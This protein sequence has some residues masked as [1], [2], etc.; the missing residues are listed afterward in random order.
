M[1]KILVLAFIASNLV[2][3]AQMFKSPEVSYGYW[4]AQEN[5]PEWVKTM[6]SEKSDPQKTISQFEKYYQTHEFV[7]NQHT[8]YYKRWL[9]SFARDK[10][11]IELSI[12][13]KKELERSTTNYLENSKA[14]L[15]SRTPTSPWKGIGPIDFDKESVSRSYAAG[16][17]HIYTVEQ[18]STNDSLLYAGTATAGL[19][20]SVDKGNNWISITD[21]MLINSIVAVEIDHVNDE[22]VYFGASNSLYKTIDGGANW[23]I[24]GDANFRAKEHYIPEIRLSP[25]DNNLLFV[26]SDFGL[27]RSTD[28]GSNFSEI[29]S[30][31]FQELEFHPSDPSIIY[32]VR[33]I[34]D[35][36]EFYKSTDNGLTF[37]LKSSGW[38]SPTSPDE[39]KRT[40][41]ATT[42]HAPNKVY[43]L[44][45]GAANGGS[46]LYGMYVSSDQ[47]ETWQRSCCGSEEAGVP[48][49]SNQ[50]LMG[51]ADDGTDDGGQYYYDLALEVDDNDSNKVF[52]AGVNLW[53][54]SDGGSTFTCPAKWSHSYK[55]NYVHADIH[56][57]KYSGDEIW[58][59]CDGGI[60]YSKNDGATFDRKMKGIE[61]T[62]FWGF[63]VGHWDGEVILGGAY[64]NGTLLKDNDVYVNGWLC[65][66][67]GDG[68]RGFVN[69]GDSRK[70]Y[71]DYGEHVLSGNRDVAFQS[72]T[73]SKLPNASYIVGN[74][75][76][77]AFHPNSHNASLIGEEGKLW[78]TYNDGSFFTLVHDFRST[79]VTKIEVAWSDPNTMYVCTYDGWWDAKKIWRTRDFGDT[80]IE[81]T[82]PASLTGADSWVPYDITVDSKN[83][84]VIWVARTSMYED[85]P[86]MDGNQIYKSTDGGDTYVDYSSTTLDGEYI[87]NIVHQRGSDGGVYIGTRRAVYYRNNSMDWQLFNNKLPLSTNS[88]RLIPYYRKGKLRN[89]TNRSAY[90]CEFYENTP[91]SALISMDNIMERCPGNF[92]NFHDRSAVSDSAVS[93][94]WTFEG[95][96]PE[97]SNEQNPSVQYIDFGSF[98]V[99]LKVTDAFGTS[100]QTLTD[101]IVI[102][103]CYNV[104]VKDEQ[105]ESLKVFPTT[106]K[107]GTSLNVQNK[108]NEKIYYK[109]YSSNGKIVSADWL[110]GNQ[111]NTTNL[112]SGRYLIK[113]IGETHMRNSGFVIE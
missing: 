12:E 89:G 113:L 51:W 30:G 27:Y 63:G 1:K 110:N 21:Q 84:D 47:G 8:Q 67:G 85:F 10:A 94:E 77:I 18:S 101:F 52:V 98:D 24:I 80:W 36:T 107:S 26:C 86:D 78:I 76:N 62:D 55:S 92:V 25:A 41:L 14:L 102:D 70:V 35:Q 111:I 72:S 69:P 2:V 5:L 57:I 50:N 65:T 96:S 61:G 6:Y 44:C 58:L 17:A 95:G 68:V 33:E 109:I 90:E 83:P 31:D 100:T 16:A 79:T 42:P 91:P 104:G 88:V 82:P 46:G 71:D 59:S 48:N 112:S 34:N 3:H 13:R 93:W 45:T 87:T 75:S 22:V 108:L 9:R 4:S 37:T 43:A 99:T 66:G 7:K 74:S 38:P 60:F 15:N 49:S 28:G 39:Q 40:E 54:S 64:H 81:I 103:N 106:L 11:P 32:V 97:T 19:W 29:M 105:I 20:K 23:N 53:I 56:D 73:F